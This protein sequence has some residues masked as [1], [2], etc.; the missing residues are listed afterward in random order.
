MT[1]TDSTWTHWQPKTD[2]RVK[3]MANTDRINRVTL[4]Q[5]IIN[6]KKNVSYLEI[7][8]LAGDTFLRIKARHKWGVDPD[9]GIEPVK[10]ARYY[11]KNLFNVFNRYYQMESNTFFDTHRELL[12]RFGLDVVFIDGL[13]TFAQSLTD[14]QSA[15]QYL[16]K[17]GVIMLHDC[18]P[19]SEV[20]AIPARSIQEIQKLNPPGFT[21]TW[22]GDVWKTI[23][24][25]RATRNDLH[26]F[27]I[28]CDFGLGVITRGTPENTLKYSAE[29]V[30]NL[31]YRDLSHNRKSILNLKDVVYLETFLNTLETRR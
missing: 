14:V 27:V 29:E 20:A 31:S 21:G 10:K 18:N 22:N 24:Y 23:A 15:L 19:P 28:D 17:N 11:L 7:G 26:I 8:V 13:H 3:R 1:Q 9:F 25:L 6:R 16:N 4:L 30:E 5:K 12:S 2:R